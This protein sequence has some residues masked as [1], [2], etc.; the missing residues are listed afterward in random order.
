LRLAV[1]EEKSLLLSA[2]KKRHTIVPDLHLG[3]IV[4]VSDACRP[5][6]FSGIGLVPAELRVD[7]FCY[8]WEGVW[9]VLGPEEVLRIDIVGLLL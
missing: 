7:I 6:D 1:F 2:T 4:Y 3:H 8:V 9:G 5:C